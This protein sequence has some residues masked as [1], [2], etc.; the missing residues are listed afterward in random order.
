M[1]LCKILEYNQYQ[2][3][4]NFTAEK[5]REEPY[6]FTTKLIYAHKPSPPLQYTTPT[7]KIPEKR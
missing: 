4:V 6:I 3:Q 7:P 5:A 2:I 1:K